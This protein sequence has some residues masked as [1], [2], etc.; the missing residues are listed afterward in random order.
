MAKVPEPSLLALNAAIAAQ[1]AEEAA[2]AIAV[3]AKESARE[4]AEAASAVGPVNIFAS[5]AAA[6]AAIRDLADNALVEVGT[7]ET[8]GGARTRYEV[9]TGTLQH[10]YTFP[11]Q[12]YFA[13]RL[14]AAASSIPISQSFLETAGYHTPGDQGGA[15]YRRVHEVE[16]GGFTDAAGA[17][18]GLDESQ[19]NA[20]MFGAIG[21][22][23]RDDTIAIQQCIDYACYGLGE[24]KRGGGVARL[25]AGHYRISDTL[26]LGYGHNSFDGVWLKGARQAYRASPHFKGT[27]IDASSF[28]DRPAINVQG[29]RDTKIT[30]LSV[31]G[32]LADHVRAGKLV[33]RRAM[34]PG[35]RRKDWLAPGLHPNAD[36]RYAPYAGI[37]IDAYAGRR[38]ATS[39]P[40]VRYPD[41][42]EID[43]QYG[44]N[45]SS[46][47]LIENVSVYGFV[48][49]VCQ[50]PCDADGNGDFTRL[51]RVHLDHCATGLSLGNSQSRVLHLVDCVF[52]T[53]HTALETTRNG[54]QRGKPSIAFDSCEL[55]FIVQ[56]FDVPNTS[57]GG[58]LTFRSCYSE[59]IYRI[60]NGGGAASN[61]HGIVFQS[62]EFNFQMMK[63]RGV[64]SSILSCRG[65]HGVRFRDCAFKGF[66]PAGGALRA[67]PFDIDADVVSMDGCLFLVGAKSA[68]Q[69]NAVSASGGPVFRRM[70]ADMLSV[71]I[72]P[73]VR[74]AHE[75]AGKMRLGEWILAD[76][77]G[78]DRGRGAPLYAREVRG[79]KKGMA[80]VVPESVLTIEKSR[81]VISQS[82]RT[83]TV[84]VRQD[85]ETLV[86]VGGAIGDLVFDSETTTWF[87]VETRRGSVLK[88]YALNN[89]DGDG[90][91]AVSVNQTG[92]LY[93]ANCRRFVLG[94]TTRAHATSGEVVLHDVQRI[95]GLSAYLETRD[96]GVRPGDRLWV[97]DGTVVRPLDPGRARVVS[98]DATRKTIAFA[99]TFDRT[100]EIS[101]L[102]LFVRPG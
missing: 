70:S 78:A 30:E 44:K 74:W 71:K 55:S 12:P 88:L 52:A 28:S 37:T 102:G 6:L 56:I 66:D 2:A 87:V 1:R 65:P 90:N 13:T 20:H 50:Q 58:P 24:G 49:G 51:H 34:A 53:Q 22:G 16:I 67:Y 61:D 89:I 69:Q 79:A 25:L 101:A 91:L 5:H 76:T 99:G 48:I 63:W 36:S 80:I 72:R 54:R 93:A 21:D 47:V 27:I 81:T 83:V 97:G 94:Q 14:E 82:G 84:D 100:E 29:A 98:V 31:K 43:G 19:P 11:T 45:F 10:V 4:A 68:A 73:R 86:Q 46:N 26:H 85:D 62:C 39:Y 59:S 33:R 96:K 60:G 64:P 15:R 95:D 9:V 38:P 7:D 8:V 32:G 41:Y 57:F 23:V 3:G 77:A 42:L 92:R 18:W 40:D 17:H 35:L 75:P